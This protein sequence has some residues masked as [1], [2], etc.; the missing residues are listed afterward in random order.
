MKAKIINIVTFPSRNGF[1]L[2]ADLML[3]GIK[4]AHVH[5]E[6]N[7]GI[8]RYTVL[9]Q[10]LFTAFT[11]KLQEFPPFIHPELTAPIQMDADLFIT[12][13]H[14]AQEDGIPFNILEEPETLAAHILRG[15]DETK[16][17]TKQHLS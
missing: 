11:E 5:D 6:G 17:I 2:D 7:G 10:K 16:E 14:D 13:L 12:L 3:D 1:G 8:W 9:D 4:A 15:I